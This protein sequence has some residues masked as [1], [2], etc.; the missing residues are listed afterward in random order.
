MRYLLLTIRYLLFCLFFAAGAAALAMG[1]LIDPEIV[2]YYQSRA[3]LE[4]TLA[5]NRKIASV[6]EQYRAPI[7]LIESEPNI[8][9]RLEQI[10][11]GQSPAEKD[12]A[13]PQV[14]DPELFKTAKKI[15]E[16]TTK[17]AAVP[18]LP[19]W[20]QR[21]SIPGRRRALMLAGAA[22]I[23][24]A[25][26]FFGASRRKAISAGRKSALETDSQ[27]QNCDDSD[28]HTYDGP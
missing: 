13:Y 6:T 4:Q 21:C 2:N 5:D 3:E 10:T 14:Y 17:P 12:T 27:P 23:I 1:L 9:R 20:V 28:S 16:Q 11:L 7:A 19:E 18:A 24:V 22:L 26:I 15:L 25:F 8:L